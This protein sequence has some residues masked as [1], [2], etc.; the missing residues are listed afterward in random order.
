M[1]HPRLKADTILKRIKNQTN[2]NL[3][4]EFLCED[5]FFFHFFGEYKFIEKNCIKHKIGKW[6]GSEN[7]R[8]FLFVFYINK[9]KLT[10]IPIFYAFKIYLYWTVKRKQKILF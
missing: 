7:K 9:K 8:S 10:E 1:S 5:E 6:G 3:R 4:F 2:N